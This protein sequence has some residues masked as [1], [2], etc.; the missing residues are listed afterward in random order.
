MVIVLISGGVL[1]I[2][3][4]YALQSRVD[5]KHKFLYAQF[6]LS[7]S[8]A[9]FCFT[10]HKPDTFAHSSYT[11]FKYAPFWFSCFQCNGN[12]VNKAY[13]CQFSPCIA[14]SSPSLLKPISTQEK[15]GGGG[16][17]PTKKQLCLLTSPNVFHISKANC[18]NWLAQINI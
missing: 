8:K 16:G 14:I 3:L 6:F 17:N 13:E 5:K 12:P 7:K 2:H 4:Q 18:T 10:H 11:V 9:L 1:L 15:E